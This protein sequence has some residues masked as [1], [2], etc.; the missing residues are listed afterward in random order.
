MIDKL[1]K[2]GL[3]SGEAKVYSA[4]VKKGSSTVGPIVKES[5][6]AYSNIYEILER[7]INKGLVSFILREKTKYFQVT[8][9]E[10]M[11][12]YLD[13]KQEEL[14]EQRDSFALLSEE[15][16]IVS[17]S[18]E[19][20]AEIFVGL[21]GIK[22]AY[23]IMLKDSKPKEEFLFFFISD[24]KHSERVDDFY[25]ANKHLFRDPKID[26][27]GISNIEYKGAEANRQTK[28]WTKMRYVDFPIPGTIDIF[29]DMLLFISW[30]KPICFLIK[31]KEL[32]DY[33]RNYF[34][35][36]WKIAKR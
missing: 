3:T 21:K 24:K 1:K 36:I 20:E 10:N 19:Q 4:L 16:A 6:V 2:I 12:D 29:R 33:Y 32:A 26:L 14:D 31:S 13:K 15:I 11:K 28:A 8:N 7:L 35:S 17:E 23:E 27:N 5:G 9:L 34:Y 25:L 22:S 30:E 18:R